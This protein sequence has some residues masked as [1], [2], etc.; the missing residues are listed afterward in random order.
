MITIRPILPAF[1]GALESFELQVTHANGETKWL[2][3]EAWGERWIC[4]RWG[5]AG[6]YEIALK[7]GEMIARSAN[8]RKKHNPW[9]ASDKQECRDWVAERLGISKAEN[10]E[11]YRIHHE[12]MPGTQ[13]SAVQPHEPSK[14]RAGGERNR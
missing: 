2:P 6:Q 1:N 11:R 13:R 4:V 7:T 12:R 10:E 14:A 8:A 3:I 5:I 9:T